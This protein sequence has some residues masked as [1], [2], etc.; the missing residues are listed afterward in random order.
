VN[1]ALK[2]KGLLMLYNPLKE[3]ITRTIQLPLYYTGLT[4]KATLYKEGKQ[5]Q[6]L[7]LNRELKAAFTFTLAPESYSWYTIQ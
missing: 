6:T 1:P 7:Q 5:I 3:R 4:Q 2:T